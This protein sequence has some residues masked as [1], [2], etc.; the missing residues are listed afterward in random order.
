MHR[1]APATTHQPGNT[2][3][4][5]MFITETKGRNRPSATADSS[6]DSEASS[7]RTARS[8]LLLLGRRLPA[9]QLEGGLGDLGIDRLLAVVHA[10]ADL[11][12]DDPEALQPRMHL[13]VAGNDMPGRIVGI[14]ALQH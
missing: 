6:V 13:V 10:L 12:G 2:R 5:V 4:L 3:C 14:G 8:V 11:M 7:Y 1:K 9:P